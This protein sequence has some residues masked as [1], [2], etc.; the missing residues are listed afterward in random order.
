[1]EFN[2]KGEGHYSWNSGTPGVMSQVE[3]TI[4]SPHAR[5]GGG[6]AAYDSIVC[7]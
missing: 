5:V 4:S 7:F 6:G 3:N 1:M 2:T